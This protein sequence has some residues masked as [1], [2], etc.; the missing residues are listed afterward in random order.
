MNGLCRHTVIV[1]GCCCFSPWSQCRKY[2]GTLLVSVV[3]PR[4]SVVIN[5]HVDG[6]VS[7]ASCTASSTVVKL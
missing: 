5:N 1:R 6:T 3:G 2:G 4:R 7:T